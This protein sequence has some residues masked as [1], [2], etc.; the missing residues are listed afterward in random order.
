MI[1]RWINR[2]PIGERGGLNLTAMVC[3]QPLEA[4]DAL[5]LW[6]IEHTSGNSYAIA[7]RNKFEDFMHLAQMTGFSYSDLLGWARKSSYGE[8]FSSVD[9]AEHACVIYLPNRVMLVLPDEE[10]SS[11]WEDNIIIAPFIEV[12]R[13]MS[14]AL[15][16]SLSM[17]GNKYEAAGFMVS[18]FD[19]F[20][21]DIKVET[22]MNSKLGWPTMGLLIGGHGTPPLRL[23]KKYA[24]RAGSLSMSEG[25][26]L[27]TPESFKGERDYKFQTLLVFGCYVGNSGWRNLAVDTGSSSIFVSGIGPQLLSSFPF[28]FS[29]PTWKD[30]N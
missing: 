12:T 26:D 21:G 11:N 25:M 6:K 30:N 28:A 14:I 13:L 15:R 8:R 23:L 3:N 27:L 24:P 17:I 9:E 7:K 20:G 5:G 10:R 22:S 19:F 29:P 2:D 1:Q 16:N 4:V 18:K